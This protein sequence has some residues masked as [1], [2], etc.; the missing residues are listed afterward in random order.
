MSI[1]ILN[2]NLI[3]FLNIT[4]YRLGK[5]ATDKLSFGRKLFIKLSKWLIA[6][7][8]FIHKIGK[9]YVNIKTKEITTEIHRRQVPIIDKKMSGKSF[10]KILALVDRDDDCEKRCGKHCKS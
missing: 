10:E 5:T 6:K 9:I 3:L 1:D 7:N 2:F 4:F 8:P